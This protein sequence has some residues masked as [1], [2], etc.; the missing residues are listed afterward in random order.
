MPIGNAQTVKSRSNGRLLDVVCDFLA[1][2]S[3]ALLIA[4]SHSAGDGAVY[5]AFDPAGAG[6]LGIHRLTLVQ[7]AADLA[8]PE[9]AR[10]GLA[11]LT[12]LGVEAL[13]A[14]VASTLLK[15]KKLAYFEPV[16]ALPGFA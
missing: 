11:P 12:T 1:K 13:A 2:C 9:M 6:S 14:R 15:K 7:L 10:F 3:E 4:P 8:R 5:R 16:A